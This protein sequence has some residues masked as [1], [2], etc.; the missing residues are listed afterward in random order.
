MKHKTILSPTLLERHLTPQVCPPPLAPPFRS[1]PPFR[2]RVNSP[3]GN[4]RQRQHNLQEPAGGGSR[5]H[6]CGTRVATP[7]TLDLLPRHGRVVLQV[8]AADERLAAAL[9]LQ[10]GSAGRASPHLAGGKESERPQ[11][12]RP[13]AGPTHAGPKIKE[14]R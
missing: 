9:R 14:D 11:C 4:K 5:P 12:S 7:S 10:P 3:E 2:G 13:P 8:D 1:A 6:L